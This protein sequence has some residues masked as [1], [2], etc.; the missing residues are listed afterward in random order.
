MSEQ[1]NKRGQ[2]LPIAALI[3]AVLAVFTFVIGY[4][5]VGVGF[6]VAF[7]VLQL[8]KKKA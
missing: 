6:L 7:F 1:K 4:T 2:G 8:L 5:G 3:C